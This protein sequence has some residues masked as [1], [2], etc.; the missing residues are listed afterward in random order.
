MF[1]FMIAVGAKYQ[2]TMAPASYTCFADVR[3]KFYTKFFDRVGVELEPALD[4]DNYAGGAVDPLEE[5]DEEMGP[6]PHSNPDQFPLG[7]Q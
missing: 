5:P 6:D 4:P 7:F 1:Y 2:E 3:L